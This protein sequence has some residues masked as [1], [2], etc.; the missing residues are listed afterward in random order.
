MNDTSLATP[1]SKWQRPA[2]EIELDDVV[3][4]SGYGGAVAALRLAQSGSKVVVFERGSEYQPGQFPHDATV[5][6]KH[7][8]G[9]LPGSERVLGRAS[10]VFEWHLGDGVV[11]LTGNGLGGGSLINAGVVI[12]PTPEVFEQSAWPAALRQAAPITLRDAFD[13]ARRTLR[14]ERLVAGLRTPKG[15]RLA[16]LGGGAAEPD[17]TVDLATCTRCGD[18]AT[19]CNWGAKRTLCETYLA[20]ARDA[21]AEFVSS[22]TAR[23]IEPLGDGR[24]QVLLWPT[25]RTGELLSGDAN[26]LRAFERRVIARRL[27][28][29]AGT[30]GSTELLQRSQARHAT[31]RFSTD[32]LGRRFSANGDSLSFLVDGGAAVNAFG[33]GALPPLAGAAPDFGVGPTITMM[34]DRRRDADG[35]PHP[36]ARQVLVQDGAIPATLARFTEEM[37]AT[38]YLMKQLD[39]PRFRAA[40][41][42][43]S[44]PLAAGTW[45]RNTHV[46]L[47][48]GHDGSPGC[49]RWND[50]DGCS[51]AVWAGDA[52]TNPAYVSQ[53]AVFD[54][55][56]AAGAIHLHPLTWQWLPAG[57]DSVM[58]GPKPRRTVVTVHPLGGCAMSDGW[59]TGV[60][61]HLGRPW[62]ADGGVW[63]NLWVLDGSIVPTSL[64]ANPL[65]TITAL[66]ERTLQA[67]T[68]KPAFAAAVAA[69][70]R[71]PAV[72]ARPPPE[73]APVD[74]ALGERL[75]STRLRGTEQRFEHAEL[76]LEMGS[77]DWLAMWRSGLHHVE[78]RSGTL[79]LAVPGAAS[80]AV[81]YRVQHGWFELLPYRGGMPFGTPAPGWLGPA[82]VGEW[83]AWLRAGV[84]WL[85]CRGFDDLLR[86][87]RDCLKP[88]SGARRPP[89]AFL[90]SLFIGLAHAAE[91]REMRYR[92]ALTL[93]SPAPWPD[94][95]D[96]LTL[97]GRKQVGYGADWPRLLRWPYDAFF[98]WLDGRG[99]APP[100]RS[101]WDQVFN[102]EI[103]VLTDEV[104]ER[105]A[106]LARRSPQL[107]DAWLFGRFEVDLASLLAQ[108]PLRLQTGDLT[109][110]VQAL[111]AYPMLFARHAMKTQLFDFRL[112]DYEPEPPAD[113]TRGAMPLNVDGRPVTP[114]RHELTVQRGETEAD[115]PDAPATPLT[116]HLWHY[117]APNPR[118]P[119]RATWGRHAVW[120]APSVLLLHAFAQSGAMFTLPEPHPSLARHLLADG[121]DVW[122]L[123]QRISIRL[124]YAELPSN[125]VQIARHDIPAAVDL[126]LGA[127]ADRY[128]V[129]PSELQIFAT[130]QCVGG[131]SLA[132]SLLDGNLSHG[133]AL[134]PGAA[135]DPTAPQLSKLAGAVISQTHPF[136]V[137]TP[138]TRAKTWVPAFI[139]NAMR[140]KAV[141]FAVHGEPKTVREGWLDRLLASMPVPDDERCPGE[142]DIL[143][144]QDDCATCR[145]IRFIEA[146]L[147]R[148]TN[149]L[150]ATHRELPF[151]FGDANVHLFAHAARC[152]EAER[153]V[154]DEG[155]YVFVTDEKMRRH[156]SL[157][158]AF[159]HG[160]RNELFH[161][162]SAKRSAEQ[163]A[164]LFPGLA[165]LV[166]RAIGSAAEGAAW[167]VPEHGHV[168][169]ILGREAPAW[170]FEPMARLFG[171]LLQA[172]SADGPC[173]P[174]Q[175]QV[176]LRP[177]LVGPLLGALRREGAFLKLR[178]AFL[179]D[180]RFSD[181][182]GAFDDA[183]GLRTWAMVRSDGGGQRRFHLL[184]ARAGGRHP[185]RG[186]SAGYR[187]AHGELTIA[188]PPAGQAVDLLAFSLHETLLAASRADT[189]R[190]GA[191]AVPPWLAQLAQPGDFAP[192]AAFDAWVT[193][194]LADREDDVRHGRASARVIDP[195]L[196]NPSVQR[197]DARP[198][199]LGAARLG[200][201]SLEAA[202]GSAAR[203][204]FFAASC[205]YPGWPFDR[206]RVDAATRRLLDLV[207]APG[208]GLAFGLLL[209]DQ[210][211]AD[212]TAGMIDPL[213][214]VERYF[215]RYRTALGRSPGQPGEPDRRSL[216][217]LLAAV[218]TYLTP[219]DHEY[220]DGFPDGRAVDQR[221]STDSVRGLRARRVASDALTSFQFMHMPPTLPRLSRNYTFTH[222]PVRCF[223]LDTR[224]QR[225]A[226]RNG[227]FSPSL[228]RRVTLAALA[229]WLAQPVGEHALNCI[230]S[231]SVL[232]P[233]LKTDPTSVLDDSTAWAPH[234]RAA[235]LH[236]IGS[237]RPAGRR[238]LLLAGDYH[239]S[240][241]TALAGPD[242][243]FGVAVVT[244]PLYAPLAYA[245]AV[246][247]DLDFGEDLAAYGLAMNRLAGGV[248]AGSGFAA[249]QVRR[250]G[251]GYRVEVAR[252]L[253]RHDL[254]EAALSPAPVV[255]V[256]I[257]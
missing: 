256:D 50:Q 108:A 20:P 131:A 140:M 55:L 198:T 64:G 9:R 230:A 182:S 84:T 146:P 67:I 114:E 139:G 23:W 224:T 191:A 137:G 73:P 247:D 71:P 72:R 40:G 80:R 113:L 173:P 172:S 91:R 119:Q 171:A 124:P 161:V 79:R 27:I 205:R 125:M 42:A 143:H 186:G 174:P 18:C 213:A 33:A 219:D 28:V 4:G 166:E 36:L 184:A 15:A 24:W 212:A 11:A 142:L 94:L 35:L 68:G 214:P 8:R 178:V 128:G 110:G 165:T 65:L 218:P 106:A 199:A 207:D 98:A 49:I 164:R 145:R 234:D 188:V 249:L 74:G 130:G 122:V 135:G 32:E 179:I 159:L 127:L 210:I 22:A 149:L 253:Q 87:A 120:K 144:R 126:I 52:S 109:T 233:L 117:R 46:L 245:N 190:R 7:L 115:P 78:A 209:G 105:R 58:S 59:Q 136:L 25:E 102:P 240:A 17:V 69:P 77:A 82:R 216:G 111:G 155:G 201:A 236:A 244:P 197:R 96:T 16:A 192:D 95:P 153:L 121:F 38:A 39:R 196:R 123:D 90:R 239:L 222:G 162:S 6:L 220:R 169:V 243:V 252:W 160:E 228:L 134:A 152:V 151:L 154:D 235:L 141:P 177:P 97:L 242:G 187:I 229:G 248:R 104:S 200:A 85:E 70:T 231:G 254:H 129:A 63:P 157:P 181:A 238:I 3:I 30:F 138:Q 250:R 89:G 99:I 176:G 227:R 92:L 29:A 13:R 133:V 237:A 246:E 5:A 21:G 61:D 53:Q 57:A 206:D 93:E 48:M 37:L 10:G 100:K 83:L 132:I 156:F 75:V 81:T 189:L 255:G 62:K 180:D 12:E 183:P 1:L 60:V 51:K 167:I 19:G 168:D 45:G 158:M 148:H 14:P 2:A 26:V 147:F 193:A 225:R 257:P 112:P 150:P 116:L 41:P 34:L 223:V 101:F 208:S 221:F 76:A 118:S 175:T 185:E 103:V 203:V 56:A 170:V 217:D 43:G 86:G 232:L 66:A 88:R 241:V 194:R 31:L 163:Y 202:D 195:A 204:E 107:A 251:A 44:D 215:E 211:Y 54:G 226:L 47:A